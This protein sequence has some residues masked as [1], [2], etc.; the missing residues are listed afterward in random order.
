[1]T[2]VIDL[3]EY[4]DPDDLR[5][6]I[7]ELEEQIASQEKELGRLRR[8]R[9]YYLFQ[10]QQLTSPPAEKKPTRLHRLAAFARRLRRRQC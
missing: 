7:A 9:G 3:P 2:I 1:M 10:L 6:A 5:R 4:S 8:T